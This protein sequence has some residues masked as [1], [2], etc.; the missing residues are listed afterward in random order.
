MYSGGFTAAEAGYGVSSI[1][2][3]V[4]TAYARFR[5]DMMHTMD[6]KLRDKYPRLLQSTYHWV[7]GH[8][9]MLEVPTVYANDFIEFVRLVNRNEIDR[10]RET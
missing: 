6:W 1:P 2:T 4:P 7:G 8:F 10:R 9:A 3:Q 5:Q